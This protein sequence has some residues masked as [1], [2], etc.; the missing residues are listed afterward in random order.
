M[1]RRYFLDTSA[2]AKLYV[3]EVGTEA[4]LGLARFA[5]PRSLALFSL[6]RVELHSAIRR[7]ARGGSIDASTA[8]R[9]LTRFETHWATFFLI[10]PLSEGVIARAIEVV[11]RSA[12]RAYDAMQLAACLTLRETDPTLGTFVC[13]DRELIAAADAQGIATL[14]PEADTPAT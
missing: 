2:L 3:D 13:T 7:R 1:E 11:A 4:M 6:S 8:D 10:L 9:L 5:A 14:N 12:L